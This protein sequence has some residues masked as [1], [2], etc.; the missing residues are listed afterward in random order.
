VRGGHCTPECCPL[1]RYVGTGADIPA[2][3][4]RGLL[5]I[6][7]PEGAN[8]TAFER[9]VPRQVSTGRRGLDEAPVRKIRW[10]CC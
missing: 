9:L 1:Y 7:R 10:A 4:H 2:V 3:L 5:V 8:P 6:V